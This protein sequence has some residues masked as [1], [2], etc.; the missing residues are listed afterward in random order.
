[1]AGQLRGWHIDAARRCGSSWRMLWF[2]TLRP[3]EALPAAWLIETGERPRTRP[4]RSALRHDISRAVIASQTGF[5]VDVVTLAHDAAG[6]LRIRTPSSTGLHASHATRDG[7]VLTALAGR[8]VGADIETVGQGPIPLGALHPDEQAW[9]A[10]LSENER[11][12]AF[13]CLWAAKEAHGKWA[14]TGL[15]Q[16]DLHPVLPLGPDEW[17]AAGQASPAITTRLVERSG[18]RY[19]LAVAL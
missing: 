15:P 11:W 8:P 4:E 12:P 16:T 10:R 17:R 19:A 2:D 6:A 13:A 5:A 7:L 3:A 1:M 18:R 9:L 14:G